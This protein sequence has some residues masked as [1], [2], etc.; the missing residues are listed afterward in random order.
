MVEFM[1]EKVAE[2]LTHYKHKTPR[3]CLSLP[4]PQ[5]NRLIR[6]RVTR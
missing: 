5:K 2:F 3:Y 1:D 4:M 6:P